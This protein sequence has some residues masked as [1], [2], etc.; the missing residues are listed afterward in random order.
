M[1]VGAVLGSGVLILPAITAQQSGPAS[2]LAWIGMSL[3]A[4]PLSLTIGRLGARFP[5]AGG[6]AE[7]ARLAFGPTLGRITGWLFAGT[8]P[9]GVP[10]IALVGAGYAVGSLSLP[11]WTIPFM[12]AFMLAASLFLNVRGIEMAGWGQLVLIGLVTVMIMAAILIAMPHIQH[13]AVHPLAPHGWRV[14]G[15]SAIMIFW[16]FVGWEMVAHLAEEFGHPERDLRR[17]FAL[18]PAIVGVLYVALSWVTVGTHSYGKVNSKTSMSHLIGTG[19]GHTG[20]VIT[21]I[22]ALVITLVSI[23]GNVT[24]FS[25]MVYAQA[26]SGDF[27]AFLARLHASYQTPS[28]V[29]YLLGMDFAIVVGLYSVFHVNLGELVK[30]PSTVFLALYLIAMASAIR[31]LRTERRTRWVPW[32]PFT[33]CVALYPFAGWAAIYPL[34][35]ASLGWF[36]TRRTSPSVSKEHTE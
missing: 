2:I 26:R 7:Y 31:L 5:H 21:G 33:V 35:L 3:L 4:F 32:I 10:I 24:G 14:L 23:H 6:I 29:L 17:T 30:W 9:I 11:G 20:S 36:M 15:T 25:R 22:L 8:I 1:A 27:P 12:A 16:C 28:V 13:G 34:V 19:L 18:A